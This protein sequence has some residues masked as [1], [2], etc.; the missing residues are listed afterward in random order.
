MSVVYLISDEYFK[1]Q[2]PSYNTLDMNKFYSAVLVE[3]Q[4]S[5]EDIIG[6]ILYEWL[7][8]N[9]NGTLTGDELKLL[10]QVQYLLVYL[11]ALNLILLNETPNIDNQLRIDFL[12]E[13]IIMLRNKLLDFINDSDDLQTIIS[14]GG[15][16]I[17][18]DGNANPDTNQFPSPIYY[19][20]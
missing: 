14:S 4:T 10:E 11:T 5:V 1:E 2:Y 8:A 13:K 15:G 20:R 18:E 17:G 9:A 16:A 19:W 12:K 6:S 3:Q 7:I